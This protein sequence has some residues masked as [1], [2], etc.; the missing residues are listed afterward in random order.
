M[1]AVNVPVN[2]TF[3]NNGNGT[4]TFSFNPSFTQAGVFNVTFI[5]SDGTLADSEIVAIT[6]ANVNRAPVLTAL[7]TLILVN[8]TGGQ[9]ILW[10]RAVDP[11]GTVPTLSVI[12]TPMVPYNA[13]LV[14]SGNGRGSLIWDPT[15]AQGDSSYLLRFIASDGLLADTMAV[16][17]TSVTAMRGDAN[18]DGSLDVSDVVYLV[19]YI[20]SGGPAPATIRNGNADGSDADGPGAIDI[21]DAVYLV[22]YIF[23]GGPPP[24]PL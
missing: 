17:L 24:P 23:S 15:S 20:F 11:D 7:D 2:A 21:S 8:V 9:A 1:T 3:V 22:A 5:A 6:V 4:G 13:V 10:L 19:T 12:G 18:N 16:R 14:D